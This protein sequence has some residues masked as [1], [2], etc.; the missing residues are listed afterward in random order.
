[1]K[2][3]LHAGAGVLLAAA[4]LTQAQAGSATIEAGDGKDR[5]RVLLEYQGDLLRIEPQGTSQGNGTMIARDGK[6]FVI[7]GSSVFELSSMA[8]M[9]GRQAPVPSDAPGN[10]GQFLGLDATGRSE[11]VAGVSGSVYLMRYLDESGQEHRDELVL[12]TDKRARELGDAMQQFSRTLQRVLGH[13]AQD[14]EVQMRAQLQGRGVLRYAQ[15]FRV[16]SFGAEP[17]ASRFELPSAPQRLPALGGL[18]GLGAAEGMNGG[19]GGDATVSAGAAGSA[20]A[21]STDAGASGAAD[22]GVFGRIF[23]QKAQRQQDRVE[24]RSNAEVDQQTDQAVDK[25]LDK[26]FDKLFGR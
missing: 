14:G 7:A 10:V 1:M 26:A 9:M 21:A 18:G 2:I 11:S 22:G 24:Q 12:S 23:G 3:A 16:A 19:T 8:G 15:G 25:V 5:S 17:A 4:V 6:A 20:A 13:S